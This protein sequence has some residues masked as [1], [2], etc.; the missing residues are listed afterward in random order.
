[1]GTNA[2]SGY[3]LIVRAHG[4][5]GMDQSADTDQ[6][7]AKILQDKKE[8]VIGVLGGKFMNAWNASGDIQQTIFVLT[9]K[10][11]YQLGI[12]Y[13]RDA[14]EKYRK[15]KGENVIPVKDL[16]G[17]SITDKPVGR[18][19]MT[20]GLGLTVI[21]LIILL[22]GLIEGSGVGLALGLFIGAVWMVVPGAL[23]LFHAK[24]G[25]QQFLD[26]TYRDGMIAT[27]CRQFTEK[28][29]EAFKEKL[30]SRISR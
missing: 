15:H 20:I 11:L 27:T 30:A 24:T 13:D 4:V 21:G 25:G 26:V 28:D 7:L 17:L 18:S 5:S 29:L 8:Q 19:I 10:R 6:D 16:T 3:H 2:A 14:E 1:M 9:D 23:M 12:F 22:A